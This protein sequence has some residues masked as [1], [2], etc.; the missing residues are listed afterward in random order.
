MGT[1]VLF[2]RKLHGAEERE[3]AGCVLGGRKPI[4]GGLLS[5][6]QLGLGAS[7]ALQNCPTRAREA[8]C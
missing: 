4:K 6:G 1:G 3:Q 5:C 2:G 8:E 7:G